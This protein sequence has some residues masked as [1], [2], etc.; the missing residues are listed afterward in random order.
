MFPAIGISDGLDFDSDFNFDS[1]SIGG[2]SSYPF[3]ERSLSIY[4]FSL[5]IFF[6]FPI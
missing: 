3:G 4:G 2:V 1:D 5:Y 6:V